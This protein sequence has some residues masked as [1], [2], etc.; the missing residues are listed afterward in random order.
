MTTKRVPA[1]VNAAFGRELLQDLPL[2]WIGIDIDRCQEI[3]GKVPF[4]MALQS[5]GL[6]EPVAIFLGIPLEGRVIPVV[7]E[8]GPE[9]IQEVR[10]FGRRETHV[11]LKAVPSSRSLRGLKN[12]HTQC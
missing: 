12:R 10:L 11:P 7:L 2:I 5:D 4:A 3:E 8:R 6:L 9:G 1:V